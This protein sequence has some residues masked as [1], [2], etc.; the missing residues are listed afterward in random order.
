MYDSINDDYYTDD[1]YDG[2]P[3]GCTKNGGNWSADSNPG[4]Y[5]GGN[6]DPQG[7]QECVSIGGNPQGCADD[8]FLPPISVLTQ[9]SAPS[10][11]GDIDC[12][13]IFNSASDMIDLATL[14]TGAGV[15]V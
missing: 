13:Q 9:M 5:L 14:Y 10:A 4:T 12:S 8:P 1:S 2:D 15:T 6:N 7:G 11:C 3:D